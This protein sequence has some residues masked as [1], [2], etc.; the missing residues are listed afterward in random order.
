MQNTQKPAGETQESAAR[1][2]ERLDSWK[3]IA[4][5]FHRQVRTVQLWEKSEGLPVRR[6]HHK[7]LGSVFAYR[8]ELEAWWIARSRIR[9]DGGK[10]KA[11][12]DPA[13]SKDDL[14]RVTVTPGEIGGLRIL[15][16]PIEFIPSGADGQEDER[17]VEQ[18]ARGL[19]SDLVLELTR[20]Q[21]H[22]VVLPLNA[23]PSQATSAL[24]W[25]NEIASE[26]EVDIV[27][28]G[29]IRRW[30][31]KLRISMQMVRAS[32]LQCLWSDRFDS[33]LD[34][35]FETQAKLACRISDA[36]P[37]CQGQCAD[38]KN[39]RIIANSGLAHHACSMGFHSWQQRG[40]EALGKALNYFNDAIELDPG[41]AEA[42]AGLAD[43]YISLS[44]NH[45][46]SPRKA[47]TGAWNAVKAALELDKRSIKVNNAYINALLH[48]SW[49]L[50]AAER[51]CQK[52]IESGKMDAR[53]IQL[54][55][56]VM[57]L[58]SRHQD[59]VKFA[60]HA[61]QLAPEPSL[62][63]LEG[64]VSLAYFY[65]GDYE[66]ALSMA[67]RLVQQRPQHMM[68][69]VL[70]GRIEAQ[71]RN[72]DDAIA[73]FKTSMS[74]SQGSMMNQA[75]LAYAYAGCGETARARSVLRDLREVS[76]DDR[77][78]AYE[79][80]AAYATLGMEQESLTY[81]QKALDNWELMTLFL[82]QDPRFSR[83][84]NSKGFQHISSTIHPNRVLPAVV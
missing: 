11:E 67:R 40:V 75:L 41:C 21:F 78:A 26:L 9:E 38:L 81:I 61:C 17:G 34:H 8:N 80:S 68:G 12:Q 55:S 84:R 71:L 15:A 52:M 25:A 1:A 37:D 42:Y 57:S 30:G 79:V 47:A 10:P 3:E 6:Q 51:L 7:K 19:R 64:Q 50:S 46:I 13:S 16:L 35:G 76:D 22:P 72:W 69:Y 33:E 54:Y 45:M 74:L 53:T 73:A 63:N 83:L 39:R 23:I 28:S 2:Q 44:Y 56:S 4:S 14:T 29:S 77:F 27:L 65:S 49:N 59:A 70:L 18:F 36:L 5:F 31:D 32:D 60:L 24:E 48:C 82:G 20:S 62:A 66:R 43:T 58:R